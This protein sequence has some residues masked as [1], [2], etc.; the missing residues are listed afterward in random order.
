MNDVTYKQSAGT[1]WRNPN[2]PWQLSLIGYFC[3]IVGY[4]GVILKIPTSAPLFV[5][6]EF[7]RKFN[8]SFPEQHYGAVEYVYALTTVLVGTIVSFIAIAGGI[9]VL[10]L[11]AWGRKCV[12][13]YASAA[14]VMTLVK[15]VWTATHFEAEVARIVAATTQTTQPIEPADPEAVRRSRATVLFFGTISQLVAPAA[16]LTILRRRPIR[17][18][19]P[20]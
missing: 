3:V 4:F 2:R 13:I 12:I 18:A 1:V 16:M 9:G 7:L 6:T 11:R 15:C 20:S 17:E 10:K 5:S 14:I 8:P 19:F